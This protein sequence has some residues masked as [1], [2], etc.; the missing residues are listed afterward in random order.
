MS[1]KALSWKSSGSE[2]ADVPAARVTAGMPGKVNALSVAGSIAPP[3]FETA[4]CTEL[5]PTALVPYWLESRSRSRAPPILTWIICRSVL[6]ASPGDGGQLPGSVVC[7]A[8]A[9]DP[10]QRLT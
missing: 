3:P 2:N 4:T 6:P 8:H 5:M 7:G 1:D 9:Q 10:T